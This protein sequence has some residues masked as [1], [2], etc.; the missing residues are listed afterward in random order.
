[1]KIGFIGLGNMGA[2][3]AR[4][5]AAAGHDVTGFDTASVTVDGVTQAATAIAAA[6]GADVVITML[7]NGA[8]LRAVAADII[9]AMAKGAVST[10]CAIMIDVTVPA[11]PILANHASIANAIIISGI[12]GGNKINAR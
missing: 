5:L 12:V 4:N 2:P 10:L 1:M 9:P 11:R 8:I 3:M 6:T 7:P